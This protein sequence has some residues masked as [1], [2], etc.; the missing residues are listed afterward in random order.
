[1]PTA[2]NLLRCDQLMLDKA[3]KMVTYK[4]QSISLSPT[5]FDLLSHLMQQAPKVVS[6]DELLEYVWTDKVVN[7]ET[8]KQQIKSL[9][10]QLGTAAGMIESVRGFGYQIKSPPVKTETFEPKD[11]PLYTKKVAWLVFPII[12]MLAGIFWY[13]N[14]ESKTSWTLPLRTATMPFKLLDSKDQDLVLLLQDELT[15]MMSKQKDVKAISVSALE[16]ANYKNYSLQ[17]YAD[18]LNVDV[19]FEGSI[20]EQSTGYQV[21]VRMVWTKTSIAIWRD[22]LSIEEKDRELLLSKT[23]EALQSFIQKK[24][25]Y[26]KSKLN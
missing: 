9:R 6:V 26:I 18:F 3:L 24:V 23:R 17:E 13:T 11:K 2:E 15:S 22:T 21:N 14:Y 19:L 25:K 12:L 7:R 10:D 4:D 20:Q 8:V 1:M 5:S 16:H